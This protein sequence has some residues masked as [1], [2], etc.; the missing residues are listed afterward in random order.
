MGQKR[1]KPEEIVAKLRQ[2]D[3]LVS[4]GRSVAEAVRSIGV[5]QF[6]YYRWRKEFGGLKTDQV[7]RLKE[8]EKENERLRKAVSDLTLEKLIL[9]EAAFGKLLSPAR[10]RAC[11]DHVRQ[12]FSVSERIACRVLGQHR[13]TQRKIPRGR[14][15]DDALTAD[16]IAL[17]SQY[18]RYGYR[19]I[20][21]M[22]RDAGWAVNVKRVER[23][24]RREGLKVSQKQPKKGRLWLNDGSCIR[25]RPER[26]NHV[27]S[28]DFVE[29]R[30][31]DGRKF[32]MLNVIDEFTRECLAIRIDR[33]LNSTAVIDTLTDLFI[34]RG[35]PGHVRSDNGP[36][37]VAKAVRDWIAAVGAKTAF[38][39]PGSP[40]E[41]GYCESFNSKLRD[42]LLDGEIFYSLAEARVVIEAWRV[43][44]NTARPHSS[45]GYRPPAPEAVRWPSRDGGSPPPQA[46]TLAPRPVMH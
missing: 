27:W 17:A 31:H 12:K 3:V 8:L 26:P 29:S 28:Y 39:E 46:S 11:V 41:N 35:V 20:A 36:E 23:I 45:L 2:V 6:T 19:R 7:K 10:R 21:A 1:H 33:K 25:L 30:T 43:H 14:A 13:S 32:R 38:I 15:D 4:Q 22:L 42:E 5:T 44:Y 34:L 9:R 16:I 40:W 24:W 37:F 18:G